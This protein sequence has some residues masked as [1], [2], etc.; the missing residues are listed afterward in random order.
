MV[1]RNRR[2]LNSEEFPLGTMMELKVST[3]IRTPTAFS[4]TDVIGASEDA[5]SALSR[6]E[7]ASVLQTWCC[8]ASLHQPQRN[9]K[10]V[11]GEGS[12]TAGQ[13]AAGQDLVDA[14]HHGEHGAV[15]NE[16]RLDAG[17]RQLH[18]HARSL[19]PG[20]SLRDYHLQS[21]GNR[22]KIVLWA[23]DNCLSASRYPDLSTCQPGAASPMCLRMLR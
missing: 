23:P 21:Q 17:L 3:D 9:G 14:R 15:R 1:G 18:R 7:T 6:S 22:I 11:T 13:A 8:A 4:L 5:L 19:V 12:S 2:E 20:R 10:A 16:R